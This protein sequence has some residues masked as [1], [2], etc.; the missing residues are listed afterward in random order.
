MAIVC[1]VA[2]D[3]ALSGVLPTVKFTRGNQTSAITLKY[4]ATT[5]ATLSQGDYSIQGDNVSTD[6]QT[7][8][9][10][11]IVAPSQVTVN[12]GSTASVNVSFGA[13]QRSAALDISIGALSGLATET[14]N[15]T[16]ADKASGKSLAAF[17][18]GINTTTPLRSLPVS[19]TAQISIDKFTV[20]NV[21]YSFAIAD[22]TLAN[23]LQTVSITDSMVKTSPLDTSGFVQLPVDI[24]A[25]AALPRQLTLRLTGNGMS[26]TQTV[27][28]ESQT[29]AFS[30]RVKPGSYTVTAP[31]FVSNGVVYVVDAPSPLVVASN[32]TTVLEVSILRSA[33]L[34]VPGFPPYLA[35]GG[36]ADLTPGNQADFASARASSVF[37]YAGNDGAGDARTYLTEDP[38]TT[39][40][41]NL[42]RSIE[43]QLGG[44]PV[45][46][47]MISYTCNLS[48]GDYPTIL[49]DADQHAHSFA[50]LILSLQTANATIDTAHPVPAGFVVNPDFLGACQQQTTG[51]AIRCLS[52]H[53]CR[54][55]WI[56]GQWTQ[57][58]RQASPRTFKATWR[59][60]TGWST[61]SPPVSCSAGR[62]TCPRF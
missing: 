56:T 57:L 40:T 48:L 36:C 39:T 9:A 20:N 53:H 30:A 31:A 61:L 6:D 8:V 16:V 43:A 14:L 34:N 51:R 23:K 19:G 27:S 37:K 50:N 24:D 44:Q 54:L 41:I 3:P 62:L 18:S 46:P 60:S 52:A 4:A 29:T 45:L 10:P 47:V 49:A 21:G 59:R 7:V 38:A 35:F 2:P 13:V 58:S 11:M 26:Y 42:A 1:A 33:N 32:G 12:V 55:H 15:V 22:V 17:S 25:E 5:S 28:V